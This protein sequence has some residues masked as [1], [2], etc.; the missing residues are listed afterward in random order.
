MTS[1][2]EGLLNGISEVIERQAR[3]NLQGLCRSIA[4]G[5]TLIDRARWDYPFRFGRS[6]RRKSADGPFKKSLAADDVDYV[7][8]V[9]L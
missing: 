6:Q 8:N 5:S 9:F 3:R 1:H 2:N 7:M 4:E